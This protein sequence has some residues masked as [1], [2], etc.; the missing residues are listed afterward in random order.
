MPIY[1]VF[2]IEYTY[3]W[4]AECWSERKKFFQFI[5]NFVPNDITHTHT[6]T[7]WLTIPKS[8]RITLRTYRIHQNLLWINWHRAAVRPGHVHINVVLQIETYIE[9]SINHN[10]NNNETSIQCSEVCTTIDVYFVIAH[11]IP[12]PAYILTKLFPP[13][14]NKLVF[15]LKG[16]SVW[17]YT[18]FYFEYIELTLVCLFVIR[19]AYRYEVIVFAFEFKFLEYLW[20]MLNMHYTWLHNFR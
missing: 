2:T 14:V 9:F 6:S 12:M 15:Y 7:Q 4:E 18:W 16:S 5:E 3:V 10:Y 8:I 17:F 1:H 11:G 20:K 13:I 19:A